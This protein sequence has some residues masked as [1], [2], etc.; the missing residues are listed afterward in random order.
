MHF[1]LSLHTSFAIPNGKTKT[2]IL[3]PNYLKKQSSLSSYLLTKVINTGPN[4]PEVLSRLVTY[5]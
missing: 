4:W 1:C 3:K 2:L 5:I